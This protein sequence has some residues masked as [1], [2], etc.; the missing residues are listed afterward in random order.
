M[1]HVLK[2]ATSLL[3]SAAT[4]A[5]SFACIVTPQKVEAQQ[6][7][8]TA[9]FINT[10]LTAGPLNGPAI[11]LDT[12]NESNL[13][14]LA[15]AEASSMWAQGSGYENPE[16]DG[17][18]CAIDGNTSSYWRSENALDK[19][20]TRDQAPTLTLTW[21]EP[22]EVK[23]LEYYD[24]PNEDSNGNTEEVVCNFYD[25]QGEKIASETLLNPTNSDP[26]VKEFDSSLND[27]SKIEFTIVYD[28]IAE[29]RNAGL[30][31]AEIKIFDAVPEG[32]EPVSVLPKL[33]ESFGIEDDTARWEYFDDR[34]FNR[35]TDDYNDLYGYYKVKQGKETKGKYVYAHTYVYSEK[36]QS[37]ELR[38]TT[39]GLYRAYVN[40]VCQSV[41]QTASRA[42]NKDE[43]RCNIVLKEG[44]NQLL[45]EFK[46][47]EGTYPLGFYAR[48]CDTYG[49]QIDGLVYSVS[50]N[51]T[52]EG[53][54]QVVTQG[55]DIDKKAFEERNADTPQNTYPENELPYG[56]TQ[57]PYVWNKSIYHTNTDWGPQAARFQFQAAG[58]APGYTWTLEKGE[59][60]PGLTLRE[61]GTID[62][63]CTEETGTYHFTV[64][65]TDRENNSATK[66]M[67]IVVKERP[68]KW[69]EEG[70][71]S[72]LT[73]CIASYSAIYDENFSYDT[74][75]ERAKEAG[76]TM[77][78]IES[79]ME[80]YFWPSKQ[81]SSKSI[82]YYRDENGNVRDWLKEPVEA[83]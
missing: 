54:L 77:L 60:P 34:I 70:K 57:W 28:Q 26:A 49:N 4:I 72:A 58:G 36:E 7:T 25:T 78:S 76:M 39:T 31:I 27:I 17:P 43:Y 19:W 55:L 22:I 79:V 48:I 6:V 5:T 29:E 24:Q 83:V 47:P 61:D 45:F 21:D 59:L 16:R 81:G 69:F 37:A 75:A 10:W 8:G 73:H 65:V 1:K 42:W 64:K 40:N 14:R 68:N 18:Q 62:G 51:E 12:Q 38:F 9:P 71:M 56:Y 30:G 80:Y 67:Q 63:Y 46:H 13:A 74:W 44:W 32:A 20:D 52:E 23:Y 3:L 15:S 50:G 33:G 66:S 41:G 53:K 82:P 11:D 35:N 2:K